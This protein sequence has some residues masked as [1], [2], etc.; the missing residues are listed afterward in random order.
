MRTL[1]LAALLLAAAACG[2]G[3]GSDDDDGDGAIAPG[4][5]ADPLAPDADPLAPD[6]GGGGGPDAATLPALPTCLLGCSSPA[7]CTIAGSALYD[8]DNYSCDGGRCRWTGCR[9]TAECQGA[10]GVA[11]ECGTLTGIPF[12]SCYHTCDA[13]ADCSLGTA[14]HDAD[15]YACDG[16]LCRWL[17]CNSTAECQSTFMATNYV[18]ATLEGTTFAA[19]Y[20]SCSA[21]ADCV[22]ASTLYDGDNWDCQSG[23]CAWTGCNSTS[24]CTDA[25]MN[26]GYVCQ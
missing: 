22:L 25:F 6:G 23:A 13:A 15:N 18:C 21:P 16:G 20:E 1:T 7:D 26:A 10:F 2:S 4:P 12:P 11:Y 5:D 24:E 8:A 19:C 9:T 3:G 14:I 17:G